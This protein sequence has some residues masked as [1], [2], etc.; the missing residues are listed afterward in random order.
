[1][2]ISL[3]LILMLML[4]LI[5][6]INIL[7]PLIIIIK[8]VLIII[9]LVETL[10][11]LRVFCWIYPGGGLKGVNTV[12]W[13]LIRLGVIFVQLLQVFSF[14]LNTFLA[15]LGSCDRSRRVFCT[16]EILHQ[17]LSTLNL[18][19]LHSRSNRNSTF[20]LLTPSI[21]IGWTIL[22]VN[23]SGWIQLL[24]LQLIVTLNQIFCFFTAKPIKIWMCK[25]FNCSESFWNLHI[26]HTCH[27]R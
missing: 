7:L 23:K 9:F 22:I 21:A 18:S 5:L 20:R 16:R 24:L 11:L 19:R 17:L 14:V 3:C 1:M 15:K 10:L 25:A 13:L 6:I 8:S 2:I 27:Q 4:I 26:Q 12:E